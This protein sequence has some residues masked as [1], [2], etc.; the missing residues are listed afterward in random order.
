VALGWLVSSKAPVAAQE[1]DLI[2]DTTHINSA[3]AADIHSAFDEN[4]PA[5]SPSMKSSFAS[6]VRWLA[7]NP[8][9]L[10]RA[11]NLSQQT[12]YSV[13]CPVVLLISTLWLGCSLAAAYWQLRRAD[14]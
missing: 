11:I 1:I 13:S 9:D 5:S 4:R 12:G 8:V 2:C 3:A 7:A 14:L 10:F 6:P